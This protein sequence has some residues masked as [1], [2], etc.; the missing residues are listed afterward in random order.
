[1][2]IF[3]GPRGGGVDCGVVDDI[4]RPKVLTSPFFLSFGGPSRGNACEYPYKIYT[5][6]ETRVHM[7]GLSV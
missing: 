6:L 3:A 7:L 2:R 4:Q 1:M 5:R